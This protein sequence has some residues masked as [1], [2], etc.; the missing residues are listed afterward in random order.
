[1][2]KQNENAKLA[3]AAAI[4]IY[5]ELVEILKAYVEKYGR[6][7]IKEMTGIADS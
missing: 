2:E 5:S 7:K 6:Q 1:M 4:E 3:N